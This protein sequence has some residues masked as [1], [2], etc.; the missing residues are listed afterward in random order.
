MD[1]LDKTRILGI[2][3]F[4]LIAISLIMAVLFW[5]LSDAGYLEGK[6]EDVL[7]YLSIGFLI[8]TIGF[9]GASIT[10]K[11]LELTPIGNILYVFGLFIGGA[12]ML[13]YL[14]MCVLVTVVILD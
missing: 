13:M 14:G 10:R 1:K 5:V 8:S 12:L 4:V 3:C 7:D 6:A 11:N 2:I 9:I